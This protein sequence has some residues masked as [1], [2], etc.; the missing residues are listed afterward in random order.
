MDQAQRAT[1]V[2]EYSRAPASCVIAGEQYIDQL[3]GPQGR[4]L[5]VGPTTAGDSVIVDEERARNV[6]GGGELR[7]ATE[8][9]RC[10]PTESSAD[11]IGNSAAESAAKERAAAVAGAG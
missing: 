3:L 8:A 2:N 5:D 1:A 9:R 6:G 4:S 7:A 10:V 11:H